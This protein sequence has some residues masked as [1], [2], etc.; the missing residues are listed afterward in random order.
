MACTVAQ[1]E[2]RATVRVDMS[3]LLSW[4]LQTHPISS[5][6]LCSICMLVHMVAFPA[7]F[8]DRLSRSPS[9]TC[10]RLLSRPSRSH[11]LSAVLTL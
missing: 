6:A 3:G 2:A 5:Q 10:S 4:C 7:A 9:I 1:S 11:S 8:E